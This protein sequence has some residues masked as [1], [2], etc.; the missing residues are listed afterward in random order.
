MQQ[1]V[2]M[3]MHLLMHHVSADAVRLGVLEYHLQH[4]ATH[5]LFENNNNGSVV[6]PQPFFHIYFFADVLLADA[7]TLAKRII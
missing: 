4:I 7:H 3:K 5:L 1:L 6:N 2:L